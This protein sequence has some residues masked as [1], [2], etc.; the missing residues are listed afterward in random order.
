MRIGGGAGNRICQSPFGLGGLHGVARGQCGG[1]QALEVEV[2][3]G[4][5]DGCAGL[6][7]RFLIV[8]ARIGGIGIGGRAGGAGLGIRWQQLALGAVRR[9]L[10][11]LQRRRV[12]GHGESGRGAFIQLLAALVGGFVGFFQAAEQR[13]CTGLIAGGQRAVGGNQA[14]VAPLFVVQPVLRQG[15]VEVAAGCRSVA[16]QLTQVG[17]HHQHHGAFVILLQRLVG[18]LFG[19]AELVV[20]QQGS[21]Q[22]QPVAGDVRR[23]A[24]GFV[25]QRGGIARSVGDQR[26]VGL[27]G[28]A[29]GH[30]PLEGLAASIEVAG[31]RCTQGDG[32]TG[33]LL[34]FAPLLL[35]LQCVEPEHGPR[36]LGWVDAK[37]LFAVALGTRHVAGVIGGITLG[38]QREATLVGR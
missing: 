5:F 26:L 36:A 35:S 15:G 37:G 23:Q 14:H 20:L 9:V 18:G 30:A 25:G 3:G 19:S 10:A 27:F 12:V 31:I 7:D 21:H 17:A 16:L 34:G 13:H 11:G 24:Y 6:A 28:R 33:S 4:L 1:Q 38:G 29:H 32:A 2:V 8:L 22:Q